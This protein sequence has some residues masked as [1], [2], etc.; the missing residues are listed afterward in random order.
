MT[1]LTISL[2]ALITF[3]TRYLFLERRL[4]LRLGPHLKH[5]LSYSAPAV[6]TAIFAPILLVH[7]HQLNLSLSNNYLWGGAT[8]ILA[9][10]KTGNV[11]WTIGVGTTAFLVVGSLL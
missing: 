7:D 10:S 9:A 3:I 5:I 11:Y 2:L 4:P 8:A 1:L 6:L